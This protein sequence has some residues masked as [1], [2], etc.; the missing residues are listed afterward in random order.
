MSIFVYITRRRYSYDRFGESIDKDI[1]QSVALADAEFRVPTEEERQSRR[2]SS[3]LVW[4]GNPTVGEAWFIW[5]NGE[6]AVR[7]PPKPVIAKAMQL[8]QKLNAR[9][10]SETGELF[11][12]DGTHKGFGG[13]EDTKN[14]DPIAN[15]AASSSSYRSG[16]QVFHDKF[17]HGRV[18]AVNG[19][20]LTVAFEQAG[21]KLMVARYVRPLF[22]ADALDRAI[23][24]DRADALLC[25]GR[26]SEALEGFAA[27]NESFRK[28]RSAPYLTKMGTVQWLMGNR[29]AA[30]EL[31]RSSVDGVRFGTIAYADAAGGVGQGLLLWYAGITTEDP[32]ATEH[33]LDYL[34]LLAKESRIQIWPGPLAQIVLETKSFDEIL[35]HSF[36]ANNLTEV[37]ERAKRDILTTRELTQALFVLGTQYRKQ[38]DQDRCRQV[39]QQ[40]AQLENPHEDEWYLAAAE[41]GLFPPGS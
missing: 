40:C 28:S 3:F 18:T 21:E 29:S 14:F 6:I 12:P 10:V 16:D 17:G 27:A 5:Q 13:W 32:N 37:T 25:V 2:N 36:D 38:G 20:R 7:N 26:L 15:R 19:D 34:T 22:G 39:F 35:G 33:A 11:N 41:V 9:V 4:T 24:A 31:Y 8:A 1:W 23:G 30:K